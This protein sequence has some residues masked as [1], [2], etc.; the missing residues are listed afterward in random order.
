MYHNFANLFYKLSESTFYKKWV[1]FHK[2]YRVRSIRLAVMAY[3][4]DSVADYYT[5]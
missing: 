1:S 3:P 2:K 4:M 5:P